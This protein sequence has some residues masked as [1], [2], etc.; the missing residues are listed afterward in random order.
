MKSQ[1]VFFLVGVSACAHQP[2]TETTLP[3]S[4]PGVEVTKG[5][6]VVVSKEMLDVYLGAL[7]EET[8]AEFGTPE[9]LDRLEV[10]IVKQE[11]L[12]QAAISRSMHEDP[13]IKK[14]LIL[15]QREA[16]VNGLL[17]QVVKESATDEA[18]KAW[19]ESHLVQFRTDQVRLSVIEV[20]TEEDAIELKTSLAA[21]ADFATLAKEK[22]TGPPA[23]EGGD[24]GWIEKRM[25][26][27]D[28]G[29]KV[30][31]VS[32]G[33]IVGPEQSP[34]GWTVMKVHES[35]DLV[36]FDEAKETILSQQSYA[37]EVVETYIDSLAPETTKDE[38]T[39]A[40]EAA[41]LEAS[42]KAAGTEEGP[43]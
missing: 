3:G 5:K 40:V 25:L 21:G 8:R 33:E 23:A 31:D 9:R 7:P 2:A 15:A 43:E 41:V 30:S 16:I 39:S 24:I 32:P 26:G 10:E 22:H 29:A 37:K 6:D 13:R 28:L 36:P 14:Q 38:L 35:R 19:Y 12:Y 42:Q 27:P 18:L 4:L 11:R 34:R 17:E 20:A 1:L